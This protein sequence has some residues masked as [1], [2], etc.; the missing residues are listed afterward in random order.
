MVPRHTIDTWAAYRSAAAKLWSDAFLSDIFREIDDE[1]RRDRLLA[2]LQR[3]SPLLVGGV[4]LILAATAGIVFWQNSRQQSA[5][6]DGLAYSKAMA[7]QQQGAAD[8]AIGA[9]SQIVAK[10]DGGYALLARLQA[11]EIKAKGTDH[12]GGISALRQIADDTNV[13]ET[14]RNLALILWGFFTVDTEK[15]DAVI[16]AMK[17]LAEATT[18]WHYS[19]VEITALAEL[20][21]GNR[22]AALNSYQSLADD[23]LAPRGLRARA[24]EI[25]SGLKN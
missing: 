15:P 14:Y 13:D 5:E 17:P 6:A 1:V 24:A 23:L 12:A 20:R 18:P 10:T 21:A 8:K 22:A 16:A 7:L 4:V 25:V 19:A 11:A 9:F 3:F 2:F